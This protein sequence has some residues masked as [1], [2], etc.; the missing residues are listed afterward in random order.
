[1]RK[2]K[3][4]A[5]L[6]VL[7]AAL[8]MTVGGIA[9]MRLQQVGLKAGYNN[10]VRTQGI[11]IAD[12]F[13]DTLRNNINYFE[14]AGNSISL[15]CQS[16]STEICGVLTV[17]RKPGVFTPYIDFNAKKICK[18]V[19][20][21]TVASDGKE[22]ATTQFVCDPWLAFRFQRAFIDR[23][24]QNS[25]SNSV[26]CYRIRQDGLARVTFIWRD[27][28]KASKNIDIATMNNGEK[29][30]G[31]YCPDNFNDEV[32]DNLKQNMVSIYAQL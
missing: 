21:K 6:E 16:S 30:K 4:F 20:V 28:S 15:Q 1:M 17:S 24:M 22:T 2:Q 31:G 13:V 14:T 23:Q 8:I 18:N 5:L 11:A 12:N 19:T 32:D 3:G 7:I 29:S 26:M 25:V 9:Y 10:Y 27:N